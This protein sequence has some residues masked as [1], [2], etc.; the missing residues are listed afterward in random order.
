MTQ[1]ERL[2]ILQMVADKKITASEAAELLKTLDVP[3]PESV[4]QVTVAQGPQQPRAKHAPN[5]PHPPHPPKPPQPPRAPDLGPSVGSFL[6]RVVERFADTITNVVGTPHEFPLEV[7]GTLTGT[8]IPLRINT[9]NGR[10]EVRSWDE[11]GYKANILVKVWGGTEEEAR[12]RAAD[13]YSL[14]VDEHRF[15]LDARRSDRGEIAVNV[16]LWVPRGKTYH[17]EARTGNGHVILEDLAA[18]ES[19]V[20][21]GNGKIVCQGGKAEKLFLRS[22][23]GSIEVMS[24]VADLDAG[25]GNG[26]VYI[27]PTGERSQN[28]RASTGNG[29]VRINSQQLS[30]DAGL[31]LDAHTGMGSVNIHIGGMRYERDVRSMAHKHV[32]ASTANFDQAAVQV[33]IRARTGLGSVSVD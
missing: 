16:T 6:E 29:S 23:N 24:D 25:S 18:G 4:P 2:M 1:N 14:Q 22:G 5:P 21:S 8:E 3:E 20:S 31:K 13:A 9:S 7:E 33:N 28:L 15:E 12:Q 30:K 27:T 10:V 19:N 26:S 17:L 11:P 32:I